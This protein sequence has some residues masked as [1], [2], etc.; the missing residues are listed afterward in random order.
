APDP[1][2][3]STIVVTIILRGAGATVCPLRSGTVLVGHWAMLRR[4]VG[5]LPCLGW[6]PGR[7]RAGNG[8]TIVRATAV[9][10]RRSA[11]RVIRSGRPDATVCP[12]CA[13]SP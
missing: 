12:T 6:R 9:T 13:N 8:I 4:A 11:R 3:Y 2:F 1:D 7:A 5:T 10:P